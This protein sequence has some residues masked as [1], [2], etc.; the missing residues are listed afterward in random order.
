MDDIYYERILNR[1]IQGRLRL[2]LGD[3]VL[4]IYEPD[5][6]ILEE[7]FEIYEDAYER[8][9]FDGVY[10]DREIKEVLVNNDLW[11]P[12]DDREADEIQK[13]IENRKVDAFKAFFRPK[14]LKTIKGSI[15]R[16]ERDFLKLK[17]KKI[18]FDY[19]TCSG[20]AN[21]A[22]KSWILSK[23]TKNLD[24]SDFDFVKYSISSILEFYSDKEITPKDFRKVARLDSWRSMWNSSKDRG[25]VFDKPSCFLDK[26]QLSLVSYSQMYDNVYESME[27]PDDKIIEDDDCLDGWFIVQRRK[28][29]QDRKERETENLLSNSKIANSQEVFL[30]ARSQEEAQNIYDMN[31]SSSRK[32]LRER[33]EFLKNQKEQN[34]HFKNLPDVVQ[35][36]NMDAANA[37]IQALKG[38]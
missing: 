3:L 33:Q 36:R 15:K 24:G 13:E 25:N 4:F 32:V 30:T 37:G 26:N 19:L 8:A 9:Y 31:S 7:S 16:M 18:Q 23:T 10:I 27:K 20:V 34:V 1:I 17:Q 12:F 11:T 6:D 28:H 21:F 22:R 29:E 5:A 38:R 2:K 14:E 35:Q